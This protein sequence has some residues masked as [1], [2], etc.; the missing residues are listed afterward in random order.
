MT[1]QVLVIAPHPDDEVLGCGGVM[2]RHSAMGDEVHVV[3]MSR[4]VEH[5]FE[6][7]LVAR[8][9]EELA[10]AHCIIGVKTVTYLDFPAPRLDVVPMHEM[11]DALLDKLTQIKP[12]V[13]YIP[14]H[15]DLHCDHKA[16]YWASLVA[17]RPI[18]RTIPSRVL[19]Y[20]TP[21][22]TEWGGPI[23]ADVFV[24]TVF[25]NISPYIQTKLQAMSCYKSQLKPPPHP[26]S[27]EAIEALAVYRG[28]AVSVGAAESFALVREISC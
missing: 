7:G 19:C 9:R 28:A 5:L 24:P 10:A 15:G 12:S 2:A 17:M 4:G 27:L 23:V 6:A 16:T 14:H 11:A 26:R 21:S 22:E 13:V 8:I 18:G 3:V 1:T 20:E 25:V